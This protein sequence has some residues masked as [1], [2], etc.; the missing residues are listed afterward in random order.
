MC[1]EWFK[2]YEKIANI[3]KRIKEIKGKTKVL[4]KIIKLCKKNNLELTRGKNNEL[5]IRGI[6]EEES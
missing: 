2:E 5:I 1:Q 6:I 3:N 4:D